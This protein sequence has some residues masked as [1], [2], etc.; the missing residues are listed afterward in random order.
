MEA[1][2]EDI[3]LVCGLAIAVGVVGTVLPVIPGALLIGGAVAVWALIAQTTAGW[4]VLGA[5]VLLLGAGQVLKYLTAGRTMTSSGVPRRSLII[6]GLAG[7]AGFFLIPLVGLP[8]AFV[9]ALYLAERARLGPGPG[10]RQSTMVAL[11][12]VGIAI[13][14]ELTS[15]LLAAVTW[16]VAVLNGAGG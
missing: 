7:I 6:A 8:I 16:L 10:S 13:A 11:K 9:G 4:L 14:V 2:V 3:T 5:V 12:A 15:A 1:L